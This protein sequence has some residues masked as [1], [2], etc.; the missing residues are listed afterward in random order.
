[1]KT[2]PGYFTP[3]RSKSSTKD[4]RK[5]KKKKKIIFCTKKLVSFRTNN[6]FCIIFMKMKIN[7]HSHSHIAGIK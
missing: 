2:C 1:M 3:K 4:K 5:K 7:S 6:A